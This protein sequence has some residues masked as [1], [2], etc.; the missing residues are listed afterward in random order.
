MRLTRKE[1][2]ALDYFG[3]VFAKSDEAGAG[4]FAYSDGR[5]RNNYPGS[6]CECLETV[7]EW[8]NETNHG[9]I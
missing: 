5:T 1:Q 2:A 3:L 4:W 6:S 8:Y 9:R 7:V